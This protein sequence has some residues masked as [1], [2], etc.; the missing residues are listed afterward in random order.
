MTLVRALAYMFGAA[1]SMALAG[2]FWA[3]KALLGRLFAV[4]LLVGAIN[5]AFLLTTLILVFL[6][7]QMPWALQIRTI[8][9]L[10]I[11]GAPVLL[12]F[13]WAE[14]GRRNG[15]TPSES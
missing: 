2:Q 15:G 11:G 3:T 1:G 7:H 12:F 14:A 6:D 10:M 5:C 9:A 8:N 13:T 4:Y